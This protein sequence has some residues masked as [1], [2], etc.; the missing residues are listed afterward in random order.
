MNEHILHY[1]SP[2][3]HYMEALP[4]GNGA[5]GAMCYSGVEE[6]ILSLNHDTLWTGHPREMKQERAYPGWLK[7]QQQALEGQ[8]QAC[9]DTLEREC[10]CAWSQAYMPFGDLV[11]TFAPLDN[12]NY[13]RRLDLSRG[14]L[15]S[16]F[17]LGED[18]LVKTAFISFPDQVLAYRIETEKGT[19]FSFGVSVRCPLRSHTFIRD[20]ML[21]TDGECPWDAA[22][23]DP[24]YSADKRG[25]S[26]NPNEKGVSFRGAAKILTDGNVREAE[27]KLE[28]ENATEAVI[29]Y[30]IT[31]NYLRFDCLPA[32]N[33]EL[34]QNKALE[35]LENAAKKG[36]ETLLQR[37]LEDHQALYNRVS[38]E[39]KG[40]DQ[41][42]MD[43]EKRIIRY[44]EDRSDI[45]IQELLFNFGR[46]LLIA[47]SRPGSQAT[48]LQ[49]IWNNS[50]NPPWNSNYTVNINTEMNYWPV[51]P[52]AMPEL[53]EP[54]VS[55]VEKLSV[56]G[57]SVARE[58]Y[59]A[60]G[61]VSHHNTDL[62]GF[63]V[64]T[65]GN[66][67]WAS[68]PGSSGWLC[69]SLYQLYEYTLDRDYLEKRAFPILKEAARF[70]LDVMIERDGE[71]FL[72][73]ATSPDNRFLSREGK[74][75]A[76]RSGAM[77]Q[78]IIREVFENCLKAIQI[79]G[80]S[81]E[82]QA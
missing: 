40:P 81:D 62:W 74:A 13:Y 3:G 8:F 55:L 71:L 82:I 79:L 12:K 57:R 34:H 61:F 63:A 58:F 50:T 60:R 2:A 37:H 26:D 59:N 18:V 7:A 5:V 49:G 14:I 31:T 22:T 24:D 53:M 32:P 28:I 66:P 73:P 36:Y 52:C 72:C 65:L 4:L 70:Y 20:G 25:Y 19:A 30:A 45:G 11:L 56:T 17:S 27:G 75:A 29:L 10:V 42:H 9:H 64:P 15:E 67:C 1:D 6:D 48:N 43:T 16:G 76:G 41:S 46:Y 38:L 44:M 54:L 47:S 77:V 33:L 23:R 51:L 39:L 21:L 68:W 78:A 80:V 69:Q 35:L